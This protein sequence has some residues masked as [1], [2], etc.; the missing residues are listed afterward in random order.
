MRMGMSMKASGERIRLTVLAFTR[1]WTEPSMRAPGRK[2][3]RMGKELR[4][5]QTEL[6]MKETM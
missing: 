5:G 4:L 1:I 2:I 6:V 3:V